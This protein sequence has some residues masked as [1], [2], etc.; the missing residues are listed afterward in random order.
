[1]KILIIALPRTGSTSLLEKYSKEFNLTSI[2]EPYD[3][4]DRFVYNSNLNDV[5]MKT[6]IYHIPYGY[7]DNIN[8]YIELSKEFDEVILL[9]RKNL[10]ECAESWA[11]L[12]HFN[13]KNFNSLMEYVWK[14]V[15]NL[16][17]HTNDIINWNEELIKIGEILNIKITY[18]E[19]IFD[20]KSNER[21]RKF[22]TID[23]KKLI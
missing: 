19:D 13:H 16:E 12:K 3:G 22:I 18:Y 20:S 4:S 9:S 14:N 2:F 8:G 1:M 15:P 21:Y 5:V 10:T 11:Y 17:K 23:K 6:M 7:S